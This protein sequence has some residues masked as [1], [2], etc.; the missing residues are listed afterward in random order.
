MRG[1]KGGERGRGEEGEG[2]KTPKKC[3]I[4]RTLWSFL[5]C[6]MVFFTTSWLLS[7]PLCYAR[8]LIFLSYVVL[9]SPPRLEH[10]GGQKKFALFFTL[11][12]IG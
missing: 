12:F 10:R 9:C 3:V 6:F 8:I 5:P 4:F 7:P 11:D 1:G 2:S